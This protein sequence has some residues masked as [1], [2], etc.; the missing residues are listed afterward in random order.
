MPYSSLSVANFFIG[1]SFQTGT[2]I[3]PMK[4]QKLIYYAHGW[5][6]ALLNR[7]LINEEIHAWSYGPVIQSVY[8][9][10]K[11]FGKG[12]ISEKAPF[13]F[14]GDYPEPDNEETQQLLNIIWEKFSPLSAIELS[15]ATH[16]PG[17]PWAS[18]FTQG[19][20]NIVIPN[21]TIKSYFKSISKK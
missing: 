11:H 16:M 1:K 2:P 19:V 21:D 7:S 14:G 5:H 20:K 12:A 10:F 9:E 18:L 6:L 17:T 3:T 4:L 8:H 15:N 13:P